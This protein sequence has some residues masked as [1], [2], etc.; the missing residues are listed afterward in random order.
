MRYSRRRVII[1][2]R[3]A[4]ELFHN[5]HVR[6]MGDR[7][8]EVIWDRRRT[9]DRRQAVREVPVERRGRQRRIAKSTAILHTRGFF[10]ARMI[11]SPDAA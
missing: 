2:R 10:A 9:L 4:I 5:L 3:G 1:V 8:A 11:G 7:G 6:Y